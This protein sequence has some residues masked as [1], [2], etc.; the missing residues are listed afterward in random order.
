MEI[1]ANPFISIFKPSV[2]AASRATPG[3]IRC[4]YGVPLPAKLPWPIWIYNN[5]QSR[6]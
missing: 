3:N 5:Q 2:Y 6:S 4:P 1:K